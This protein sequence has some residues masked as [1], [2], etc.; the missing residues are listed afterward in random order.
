MPATTADQV[1]P[2]SAFEREICHEI[3]IDA[4]PA[5]VWRTLT[6]TADYSWNPF[7][8]RISGKLAAGEKIQ[9]EIQPPAG[10]AMKFKPTVLEAEPERRLRW[11]GRLLVPGLFDGEHSFELQPL[12]G[13]RTRFIQ[14]ER[15]SGLLV[16]LFRPTLDKT[17]DGFASMDEALKTEA[18][19]NVT[20][21]AA[22]KKP[23]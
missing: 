7:I 11:L 2:R 9:V 5:A 10:R 20:H 22:P 16:G 3:E 15:F 14:R 23:R 8:R 18:V 17:E 21:S 19:K 12:P 6:S 13:E 4:P 1:S